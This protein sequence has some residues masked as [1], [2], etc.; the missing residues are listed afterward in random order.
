MELDH[1]PLQVVDALSG[2]DVVV[3]DVVL[4]LDV[5]L[6]PSTTGT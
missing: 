1:L 2:R 4:D 6:I 5:V 3:E